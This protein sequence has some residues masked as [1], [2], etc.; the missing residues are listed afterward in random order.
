MEAKSLFH[1]SS[2][3]KTQ[4]SSLEP[5]QQPPLLKPFAN[6][7]PAKRHVAPCVVS[8]PICARCSLTA[9]TKFAGAC[10]SKR[11]SSSAVLGAP[12]A[13]LL[14]HVETACS[15]FT[16]PGTSRPHT[17]LMGLHLF[18]ADCDFITGVV[19]GRGAM[20]LGVNNHALHSSPWAQPGRQCSDVA[21]MRDLTLGVS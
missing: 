12:S 21:I 9:A 8:K 14:G 7:K 17:H 18:E 13:E 19:F 16:Q 15:A 4:Q 11:T 3:P 6:T 20:H 2:Q 1:Q 10:F 5:Q